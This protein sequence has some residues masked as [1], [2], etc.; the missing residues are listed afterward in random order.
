MWLPEKKTKKRCVEKPP[1]TGI[2]CWDL[3]DSDPGKPLTARRQDQLAN[4]PRCPGISLVN[5]KWRSL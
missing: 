5:G 4:A 2:D 3:Q 1:K